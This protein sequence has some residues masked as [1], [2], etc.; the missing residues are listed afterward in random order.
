MIK[1]T[2]GII[3]ITGDLGSQLAQVLTDRGFTVIGCSLSRA[4]GLS[5]GEVLEQA[6][7]VHVCA[8]LSVMEGVSVTDDTLI[9]L[10]D[11][12]MSSSLRTHTGQL[13]G[14][15]AIVHMLMNASCSVVVAEESAQLDRTKQHLE[16]LG[17]QA[18]VMSVIEH[19][20]LMAR[21][22]APLA[23]L[24]QVLLPYLFEQQDKGL[25]TPSGELL[26]S[27]LHSRQL[28][29]TDETIRSIL[30]NPELKVLLR[31]MA[32]VVDEAG[33]LIHDDT[34]SEKIHKKYSLGAALR[35]LQIQ[36]R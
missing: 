27:T 35:R 30:S 34:A 3:G 12:V 13:E 6:D 7:I 17:Y 14:R 1:E 11:S 25:L 10:H 33:R 36:K 28:A 16:V 4:N 23:I 31:E 26:V 18:H 19:D 29:W 15:A 22:Q 24:C 32:A 9:V 2:V 20:Q 8:P 21:S 5:V